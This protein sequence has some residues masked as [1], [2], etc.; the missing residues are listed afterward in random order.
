MPKLHASKLALV[1]VGSALGWS[2]ANGE[3]DVGHGAGG[4]PGGGGMS[5]LSIG[6][7]PGKT[8]DSEV[9]G[10]GVD[11]N[12]NGKADDGCACWGTKEQK[13][14]LGAAAQAGIGACSWGK[15]SC[16]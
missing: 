10:N 16:T 13:C 9:C 14:F 6:G 11:D 15:Q 5:S 1:I 8:G 7:N 2:C 3:S 4:A 12:A